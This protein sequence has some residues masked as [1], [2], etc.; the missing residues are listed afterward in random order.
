MNGTLKIIG[1]FTVAYCVGCF[2]HEAWKAR[3]WAR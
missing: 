1:A 2:A 3:Q